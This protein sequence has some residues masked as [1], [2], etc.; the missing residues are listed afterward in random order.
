MTSKKKRILKYISKKSKKKEKNLLLKDLESYR[1]QNE[2]KDKFCILGAK[3]EPE[4]NYCWKTD[5]RGDLYKHKRNEN[6]PNYFNIRDPYIRTINGSFSDKNLTKKKYFKY[7]KNIIEENDN[8]NKNLQGLHIKGKN[9]LKMEYDQFKSI[10]NRKI[11]NNY[12][13][14]LP[15]SHVEDIIFIDKKYGNRNKTQEK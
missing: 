5:L 13:L 12:E 11:I 3:L 4:H 14:Y 10:K 1:V 2:L 9:L 6:N 15:S 8:I 7:Y